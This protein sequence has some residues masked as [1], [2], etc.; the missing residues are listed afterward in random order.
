MSICDKKFT[1]YGKPLYDKHFFNFNIEIPVWHKYLNSQEYATNKNKLWTMNNI[2]Q[3]QIKSHSHI[4]D[5]VYECIN[6]Q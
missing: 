2:E 6:I 5:N 3:Q 4:V 1:S